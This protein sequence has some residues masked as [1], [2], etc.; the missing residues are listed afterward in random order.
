MLS[1]QPSRFMDISCETAGADSRNLGQGYRS[2]KGGAMREPARGRTTKLTNRRGPANGDEKGRKEMGEM[3]MMLHH[4]CPSAHLSVKKIRQKYLM[5]DPEKRIK[6][7]VAKFST[8]RHGLHGKK[9][10]DQHI[11]SSW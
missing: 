8:R 11:T 9:F 2:A 1:A 3:G 6:E 10:R 5:L 4:A 7:D